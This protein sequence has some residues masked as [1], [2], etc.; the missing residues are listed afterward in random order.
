MAAYDVGDVV[1]LTAAITNADDAA[2]DP[3]AV[4]CAVKDPAGATTTNKYGVATEL[5]RDSEGNYHLDTN[6]DTA[7]N[8]HHAWY[9]SGSGRAAAEGTFNVRAVHV[10]RTYS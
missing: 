6:V 5:V 7:G 3:T 9:S 2:L 8:W 1:R 10:T 4:Y